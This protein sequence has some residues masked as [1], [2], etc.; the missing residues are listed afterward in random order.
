MQRKSKKLGDCTFLKSKVG[1]IGIGT[2]IV[3][4]AMV[5][6]AGIAASVITQT[7]N[8]LE[9]KAVQAGDE[10]KDEVGTGLRVAHIEGQIGNR[11]ISG[12]WYNNTF[13]NLSIAVDIRAGSRDID[14]STAIVEISNGTVKC[15]LAYNTGEP[16]FA[17]SVSSNGLFNTNDDSSG[18]NLYE[19]AANTFGVV[20]LKDGDGSASA[21]HPVINRGDMAK[22]TLNVTALFNGISTRT[23]IWGQVIPE[24]GSPGVFF[25]RT[26]PVTTN[27]IYEI[28]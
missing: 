5:L 1:A 27:D 17:S 3:F 2:M 11:N 14:L 13:H 6:V 8:K 26:P 4:I 25:V 10:T 22:L 24:E 23:D 7:A 12:A 18:T 15:I 21:S 28:Y 20:I 19:Q 9:I 16:N